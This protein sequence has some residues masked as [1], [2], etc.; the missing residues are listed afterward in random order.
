MESY[1]ISNALTNLFCLACGDNCFEDVC[2]PKSG[3]CTKGCKPGWHGKLC[4]N[5]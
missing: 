3:E 4:D 5:S 1:T 2:N